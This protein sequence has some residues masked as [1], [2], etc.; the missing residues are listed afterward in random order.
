MQSLLQH[1]VTEQAERRPDAV[2]LVMNEERINLW[3]IGGILQPIG[4]TPQGS[5]LQKRRPGLFPHSEISGGVYQHARNFEGRLYSCP[6]GYIQPGA[7][8]GQN[9]RIL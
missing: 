1:W 6:D 8:A 2:A 3:P 7:E 9:R 5:G 4:A